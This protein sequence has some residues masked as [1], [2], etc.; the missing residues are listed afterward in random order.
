MQNAA[1]TAFR[2]LRDRRGS[3]LERRDELTPPC[4]LEGG[5]EQAVDGGFV[6]FGVR[7]GLMRI[8]PRPHE[9]EMLLEDLEK[10]HLPG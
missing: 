2:R 3:A 5:L 8:L 6:T 9:A 4:D 10:R 1:C 7:D